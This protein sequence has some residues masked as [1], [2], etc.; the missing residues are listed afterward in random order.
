MSGGPSPAGL[1]LGGGRPSRSW[2]DGLHP[3]PRRV[4]S[5]LLSATLAGPTALGSLAR[6]KGIGDEH[7][8]S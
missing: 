2:N 3:N 6:L 7:S 5:E 8:C 1:A 4:L